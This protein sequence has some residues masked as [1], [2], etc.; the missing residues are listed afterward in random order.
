VGTIL[1]DE[2][3]MTSHI[4]ISTSS[5]IAKSGRILTHLY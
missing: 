4:H 2:P 5:C 3:P 1:P